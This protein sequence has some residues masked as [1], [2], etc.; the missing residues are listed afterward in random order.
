MLNRLSSLRSLLHQMET[1]SG[2]SVLSAHQRD[3]IYA[4]AEVAGA[5]GQAKLKDISAHPL[6]ADIARPTFFRA[7]SSLIQDGRLERV[8]STR[9]GIYKII[10]S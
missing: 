3:V 6:V 9:S 2:L 10:Q 7:V 1:E 4:A 5:D 8:G